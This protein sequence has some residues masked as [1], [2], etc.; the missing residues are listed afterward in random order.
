MALIVCPDCGNN[1]SD[2]AP[3][4]IH[5]GRPLAAPG[6]G[7]TPDRYGVVCTHCGSDDVRKLSVVHTAGLLSK[8]TE[9]PVERKLSLK[10][11]KYGLFVASVAVAIA[12]FTHP[13]TVLL[14]GWML[15]AMVSAVMAYLENEENVEFNESEYPD[16]KKQW[17]RSVM[18][19]RCGRVFEVDTL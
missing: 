9:P 10:P 18:C 11:F 5:C 19:L 12:N 13:R 2:A 4:C 15:A 16:L 6:R 3:A 1:V 7:V 14:F 17:N 8:S